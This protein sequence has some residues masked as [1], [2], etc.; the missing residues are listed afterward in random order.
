MKKFETP[1]IV[2]EKLTVED[3]ITTSNVAC[4]GDF[5][6]PEEEA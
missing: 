4:V 2:V 5:E 6:M 3:I 1:A